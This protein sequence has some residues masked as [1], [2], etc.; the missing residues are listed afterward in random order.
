M[1]PTIFTLK[2]LPAVPLEADALTPDL[3]AP[4]SRQEILALPV[5]H[6][7]QQRVLGDFFDVEGEGSEDL[8]VRGDLN[9]VKG[10]GR[11]MTRGRVTVLGHVGMHLGAHMAGGEIVVAGNA[12][13]WVGAE[14]TGGRIRIRGDAGGQVGAAYRGSPVGMR[15]GTIV[16]EGSAGIELGMRMRAGLIVVLGRV[17]DFAGTQMRG[18]TVFLFGPAGLRA[19]AWMKRGTIVSFA[20]LNLLPTFLYDCSF[21]AVFLRP[22]L[23]SLAALGV[24]VPAGALDR[25]YA[26]Y[27]GDTADVGKGEILLWHE[28]T[29]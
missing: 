27:T 19:G 2:T 23:R 10:I 12:S 17:S 9:R 5:F 25:P 3:V 6:G 4:R 1:A 16:V 15:R 11:G 20:P 7:N 22:Y 21:P 8:M 26:H 14:M 24:P 29:A 18:G 28:A 13:D